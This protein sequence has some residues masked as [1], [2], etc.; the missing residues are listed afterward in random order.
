MYH[1]IGI[2]GSGMSSLAHIVLDLGYEVSG[3]DVDFFIF[4]QQGLEDRN[5]KIY[6]FQSSN[7][8]DGMTVIIGNSFDETHEEVK[9]ALANKTVT[10]YTY[11]AFLAKLLEEYTSISVVGTHGKTTTTGML[12]HVLEPLKRGYLIGDGSG[13]MVQD[14]TYFVAECCEFQD[15]FLAYYPNYAVILNM[16]LD[17]IDYFRT[18]E[19]YNASFMKF[20]NQV[21][22]GIAVNGDEH[23]LKA[24]PISVKILYFGLNE[25]NDVCA[26]NIKENEYETI[27]DLYYCKNYYA[28]ITI[29]LVGRHMLYDALGCIS[30]LLLMNIDKQFT[31][32]R[33][34]TFPGTKRRFSRETYKNYVYIDDYAHHP[35]AIQATIEAIKT[36]YPNKKIVAVFKPDRPSRI[37]HFLK[38][39][40]TS[41]AL[42]DE[43]VITA[44]PKSVVVSEDEITAKQLA[45]HCNA[46]Y[47]EYED[48]KDAKIVAQHGEAVYVF[49][50]TKDVY[51]FK[52]VIKQVHQGELS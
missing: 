43:V 19:R 27:F 20:A 3:S 34:R 49:M 31:V 26:K 9:T 51:K 12:S 38:Q 44:Y 47:A 13:K 17:H 18:Q 40:Q 22:N 24:M 52:D 30:V 35:T 46:F 36:S 14:A 2:K 25:E 41:L 29:P 7:I 4:T 10:T 8:K 1:F 50:S 16:E 37:T 23:D 15:R 21:K 42:A 5:V 48:V 28:T 11:K 32:D 39:F 45:K 6:P 33:M